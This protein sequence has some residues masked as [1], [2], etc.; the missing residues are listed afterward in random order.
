[1]KQTKRG[2]FWNLNAGDDWIETDPL[3]HFGEWM[4]PMSSVENTAH[5]KSANRSQIYELQREVS[6]MTKFDTTACINHYIDPM[7]ATGS[8]IIVARNMSSEENG[9]SSL[10]DGWNT[11][12]EAWVYS[13]RWICN[14]HE[15]VTELGC[16]VETMADIYDNWRLLARPKTQNTTWPIQVDYC[17]VGVDGH[18]DQRCGLHYSVHIFGTVCVCTFAEC[19]FI[20]TVWYRH[21]AVSKSENHHTLTGTPAKTMVTMGDAIHEYLRKPAETFSVLATETGYYE[22]RMQKWSTQKRV[23]LVRAVSNRV[24]IL[25][26]IV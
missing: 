4:S 21:R 5:V 15:H 3:S 14:A 26:W 1:M 8:L 18:N 9:G 20:L 13:S 16:D 24:W 17:L 10:I 2:A 22:S 11:I 6:T 23:R 7:K 25:S 12:W 19:L